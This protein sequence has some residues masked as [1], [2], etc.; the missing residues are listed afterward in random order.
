MEMHLLVDFFLPPKF[1][2]APGESILRIYDMNQSSLTSQSVSSS[3]P[4]IIIISQYLL[5]SEIAKVWNSANA[6]NGIVPTTHL[7]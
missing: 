1:P 6:P 7:S 3:F 5:S 2:V 4:I